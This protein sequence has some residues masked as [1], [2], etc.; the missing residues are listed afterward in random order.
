MVILSFITLTVTIRLMTSQ[1]GSSI[2]NVITVTY[3]PV[4][5]IFGIAILSFVNTIL[6]LFQGLIWVH[7]I[8]HSDGILEK[9]CYCIF[10]KKA[11]DKRKVCKIT[12]YTKS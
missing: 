12:Q 9:I 2:Q 6:S 3:M 11:D 7:T 4:I 1:P 10:W 5:V 8:R